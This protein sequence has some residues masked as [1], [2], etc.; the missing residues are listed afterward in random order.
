MIYHKIFIMDSIVNDSWMLL[1]YLGITANMKLRSKV[2]SRAWCWVRRKSTLFWIR[3][4]TRTCHK[5][6][7]ANYYHYRQCVLIRLHFFLLTWI[8]DGS[9]VAVICS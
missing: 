1:V 6:K 4:S 5:N 2:S 8:K 7:T 9:V 3:D